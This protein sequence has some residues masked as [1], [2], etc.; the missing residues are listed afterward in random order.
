MA[1]TKMD[2]LQRKVER[3]AEALIF[4]I[5]NPYGKKRPH[6][7]VA[8]CLQALE[9]SLDELHMHR[10]EAPEPPK[11]VVRQCK[12]GVSHVYV[13][14]EAN[15]SAVKVGWTS[16]LRDR[17][18]RLRRK[19]GS[20]YEY[21]AIFDIDGDAELVE[22]LSHQMLKE[23]QQKGVGKE[24]FSV[25]VDAAKIAIG[26]SME[27][28]FER[29]SKKNKRLQAILETDS[30]GPRRVKYTKISASPRQTAQPD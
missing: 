9:A 24:W 23:Y 15:G 4:A 5:K 18:A 19:H 17:L 30:Y 2:A 27:Y 1:N 29:E 11:K 3:N 28:V 14:G 16:R 10:C 20:T 26:A 22:R 25:S 12:R 7:T 8:G 21:L 13:F 6:E